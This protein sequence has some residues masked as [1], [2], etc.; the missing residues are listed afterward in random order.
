MNPVMAPYRGKRQVF[1]RLYPDCLEKA[2]ENEWPSF[3]CQECSEYDPEDHPLDYWQAEYEGC[4][5]LLAEVFGVEYGRY[6]RREINPLT[7]QGFHA[8][9]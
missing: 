8:M 2:L 3:T 7:E 6:K 4:F 5:L 9:G 1:C